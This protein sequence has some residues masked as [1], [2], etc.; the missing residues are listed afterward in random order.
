MFRGPLAWGGQTRE[1]RERQDEAG[2]A[3]EKPKSATEAESGRHGENPTRK[4]NEK[5]YV[6]DYSANTYKII[7][8]IQAPP[9]NQTQYVLDTKEGDKDFKYFKDNKFTRNELTLAK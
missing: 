3:A 4:E 1:Q 2:A 8:V 9:S 5:G 7:Y 6:A